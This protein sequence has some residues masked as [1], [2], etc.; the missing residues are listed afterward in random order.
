MIDEVKATVRVPDMATANTK[1]FRSKKKSKGMVRKYCNDCEL[2]VYVDELGYC[3]HCF[4]DR[5]H[6]AVLKRRKQGE[7]KRR[8][9]KNHT[10]GMPRTRRTSYVEEL[11]KKSFNW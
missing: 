5:T 10:S 1:T 4:P 2:M 11:I 9:G 8:I 7:Q 3:P 6:E